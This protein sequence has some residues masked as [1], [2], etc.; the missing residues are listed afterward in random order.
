MTEAVE[1]PF[2]EIESRQATTAMVGLCNEGS[3]PKGIIEIVPEPEQSSGLVHYLPHYSVV[4]QDKD[5]MK[6]RIVYDTSAR[7]GEPTLNDC[8][9]TEPYFEQS[10]QDI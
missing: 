1:W 4:Q 3:A 10:I 7:Q 9:Y 6:L 5:T 8:L 2:L